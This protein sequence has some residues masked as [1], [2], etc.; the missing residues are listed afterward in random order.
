MYSIG[1]V[2][3]LFNIPIS[4]LRYYD[5]E[6]LF[7]NIERVSGI[8]K[9][10]DNE[11]EILRIISCLKKTGME[12]RDIKLFIKWTEEGAKT[13]KKRKALFEEQ[14]KKMEEEI[15]KMNK[16]LDMLKF[17]CW[18]YEKAIEDGNEEK[19]HSLIPDNLPP[20]IKRAYENS[21]NDKNS[22]YS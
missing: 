22:N 1:E 4:T 18:Y 11:I 21:H 19:L 13:Y 7:P 9:F 5:K 2:S 3:K 15:D 20:S 6:E 14:K 10:S 16:A 8:R 12:I 17:K